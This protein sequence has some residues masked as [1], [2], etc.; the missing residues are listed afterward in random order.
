MS[1]LKVLNKFN[2]QF[3]ERTIALFNYLLRLGDHSLIL[4][5]RLSEWCSKGPLL[6]EDLA[7][8]N[9]ALDHIGRAAALYKYAAEVLDKPSL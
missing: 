6:E 4:G 1:C 5:Q 2:P 9:M 8:T 3:M 7:M